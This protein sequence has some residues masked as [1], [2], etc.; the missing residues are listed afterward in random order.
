MY[1]NI[2]ENDT[3]LEEK[4]LPNTK[5]N[6]NTKDIV[7]AIIFVFC[8]V[9]LSAFGIFGGLRAGFTV[10]TLLTLSAV[11][12]YFKTKEN[13]PDTYSV[14]CGLLSLGLAVNFS[15]TSNS[16]VRF[17]SFFLLNLLLLIWFTSLTH[18][19]SSTGDLGI[20]K[21]IFLPIFCLALPNLPN[22]ISSL[23]SGRKDKTL[24]KIF[25]GIITAV[26]FL[27]VIIP[28]L[29]SSDE[30]FS[31]MISLAFRNII[32]LIF[33]LLLGIIIGIFLIAYC[34]SLKKKELTE[35]KII[36]FK[37]LESVPIISFLSVLSIC[38]LSYLF[39]QLAYFFSA[40]SG[41]L[42]QNYTFSFSTYARRG[43]FEMSG[44]AAINFI[45]I[46]T[47]L[48]ISVK[49]NG[50]INLFSRILC[51][52]IGIFT[53]LIIT[54][55]LS[56]MFLYIKHFGMT[57]LR[58]T[59]SVFMIFLAVVFIALMIR[60][61]VPLVKV[62]KTGFIAASISLIILGAVNVN[63]VVAQYNYNA[64][65]NG[66]LKEIDISTI[67]ELGDEGIPYL[68][69]LVNDKN[70]T[71]SHLAKLNLSYSVEDYYETEYIPELNSFKVGE[72]K[73][74]NIDE[75][76]F[77]RNCAYKILDNIIEKYPQIADYKNENCETQW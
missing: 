9:L 4:N 35:I 16:S 29:M 47:V 41:F 61:Y 30:A 32:L 2:I 68:A 54:T 49:K 26:P 7:F 36:N 51:T 5:F 21:E 13:K 60:L 62:I 27:F 73:Y 48:L 69:K 10:S 18:K 76:S 59:T 63:S 25:L 53:L 55:A 40:F 75:F 71:V 67:Y 77:A 33:K 11:T 24:G 1:D 8:S 52:F 31:G 15:I 23:V 74:N 14:L 46:F 45:I 64:Y 58:I 72:K 37:G 57:E 50:K 3:P 12:I 22:A 39:S 34:F 43:F 56:K 70:E 19:K 44:I 66:A 6:I 17:W 42:P 28:L 20:I 65:K 38:Y